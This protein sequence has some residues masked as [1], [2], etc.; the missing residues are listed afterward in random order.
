MD[1][2]FNKDCLSL[3]EKL[4]HISSIFTDLNII[5]SSLNES[6]VDQVYNIWISE[7]KDE[8]MSSNVLIYYANFSKTIKNYENMMKYYLMATFSF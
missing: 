3:H 5:N 2:R 8:D 6:E 4:C 7:T 1:L